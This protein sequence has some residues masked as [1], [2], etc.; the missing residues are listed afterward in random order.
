MK[1]SLTFDNIRDA[2]EFVKF[3]RSKGHQVSEPKRVKRS[4]AIQDRVSGKAL[5]YQYVVELL[6]GKGKGYEGGNGNGEHSDPKEA[7]REKALEEALFTAEERAITGAAIKKARQHIRKKDRIARR[8]AKE[9]FKKKSPGHQGGE[10]HSNPKDRLSPEDADAEVEHVRKALGSRLVKGDSK[11]RARRREA[12]S[13]QH[14]T[15][16]RAQARERAKRKR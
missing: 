3:S 4:K 12:G 13:S 1:T 8:E 11:E 15:K 9:H 6:I 14:K 2:N 7:P 5:K 10:I 16:E